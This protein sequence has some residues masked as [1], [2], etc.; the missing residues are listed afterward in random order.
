MG[1]QVY[2]ST[3]VQGS[4]YVLASLLLYLMWV[5]CTRWHIQIEEDEISG[6]RAGVLALLGFRT[7]FSPALLDNA[8]SLCTLPWSPLP[9]GGCKLKSLDGQEIWVPTYFSREK[10]NQLREAVEKTIA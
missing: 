5:L 8:N 10:F 7:R 4:Q 6:P 1:L 9:V 3:E 2:R